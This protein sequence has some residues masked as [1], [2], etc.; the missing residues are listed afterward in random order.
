MFT[1]VEL[2]KYLK[3]IIFKKLPNINWEK[4]NF[5]EGC[6]NSPEGIYVFSKENNYHFLFAEKGKIREDKI[7]ENREEL[8]WHVLDMFVFDLAIEYAM[9][10]RGNGDFRRTLF[11]KEIELC[12]LFGEEFK[13]RKIKEIEDILKENP[14]VD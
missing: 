8:L 3:D 9:L 12:S 7:F 10:Y 14:Y 13:K 2:E 6:N 1:T 5:K 11:K 4:I